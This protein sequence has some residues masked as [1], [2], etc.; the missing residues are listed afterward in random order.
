MLL[1]EKHKNMITVFKTVLTKRHKY[2][3]KLV[4]DIIADTQ[5]YQSIIIEQ[6]KKA[7]AIRY[8]C[9]IEDV[10]FDI[11]T[12]EYSFD[13]NS[14]NPIKPISNNNAKLINYY[15]EIKSIPVKALGFS[16]TRYKLF[17]KLLDDVIKKLLAEDHYKYQFNR[18][19]SFETIN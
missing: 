8:E 1:T 13:S 10:D 7:I 3:E 17:S 18:S 2:S 14:I 16:D 5:Y 15:L 12:G 19:K 9:N 4:L 11:N 6:V